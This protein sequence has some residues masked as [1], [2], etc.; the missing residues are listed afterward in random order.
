MVG[1]YIDA[2]LK[3]SD[4]MLEDLIYIAIEEDIDRD[5]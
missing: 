4:Q 3:V 1:V 2:F 5:V